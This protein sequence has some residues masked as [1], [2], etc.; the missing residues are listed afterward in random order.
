MS[1]PLWEKYLGLPLLKLH[2]R[3]YQK[4][5]GRIGHQIPGVP[6]SLLLHTVGAKTGLAR[7]TSLTYAK[8]GDAY[9][10]V[11]SKGGE[12]TAPG[13][14][15]NLKAKPEIE[16][17][18]GPKRFPVTARIVGKDDPDYARLWQV[19]NKNNANRYE[20]YQK[21]TTRPIPVVALT[22]R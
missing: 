5:E 12:P 4:T 10:V 22:P 19:V 17:N 11:A 21:R 1:M 18:V 20:G 2:D 14:Y 7:T 16:I 8:D 13:W 6:P 9:L 3:I 15:F